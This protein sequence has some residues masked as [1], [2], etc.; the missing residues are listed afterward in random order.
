[1]RSNMHE[2][3]QLNIYNENKNAGYWVTA[4]R[5]KK[6]DYRQVGAE[7]A[8]I[9]W[10]KLPTQSWDY[11]FLWILKVMGQE[12]IENVSP[13]INFQHFFQNSL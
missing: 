6:R 7:I 2:T 13:R 9:P 12:N 1:M 4:L 8:L 3:L 10:V 11:C 5:E